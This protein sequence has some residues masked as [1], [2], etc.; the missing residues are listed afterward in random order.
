MQFLHQSKKWLE[1]FSTELQGGWETVVNESSSAD[2]KLSL[3]VKEIPQ[4]KI[5]SA[6]VPAS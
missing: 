1:D 4:Q 2:V 6:T 5:T 3:L